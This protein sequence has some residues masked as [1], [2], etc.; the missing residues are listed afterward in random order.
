MEE[1]QSGDEDSKPAEEESAAGGASSNGNLMQ[2]GMRSSDNKNPP[3]VAVATAKNELDARKELD[4]DKQR[5]TKRIAPTHNP[6]EPAVDKASRRSFLRSELRRLTAN[7]KGAQEEADFLHQV[8][9]EWYERLV[10]LHQQV[11]PE[12]EVMVE[13]RQW[14][15]RVL[16]RAGHLRPFRS[17]AAHA[18][19]KKLKRKHSEE[20]G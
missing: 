20:E 4:E 1:K 14:K 3:P 7:I 8:N 6:Q 2:E 10:L 17:H 16:R 9:M 11:T 18:R 13:L 12:E 5:G 15:R 19:N